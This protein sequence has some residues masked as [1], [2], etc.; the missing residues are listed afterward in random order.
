MKL[1]DITSWVSG[2]DFIFG[3]EVYVN[4]DQNKAYKLVHLKKKNGSLFSTSFTTYTNIDLALSAIPENSPLVL[5][6]NGKGIIH[7]SFSKNE[8]S[9]Y[10]IAKELFPDIKLDDFLYQQTNTVSGGI[11]SLIRKELIID[12][13]NTLNKKNIYITSISLG[14]FIVIPFFKMLNRFSEETKYDCYELKINPSGDLLEYQILSEIQLS[15]IVVSSEIIEGVY[16]N[17]YAAACL[18]LLTLEQPVEKFVVHDALIHQQVNKY[19]TII[20]KRRGGIVFLV[21]ILILLLINFAV[22]S[23]VSKK[24]VSYQN[25][26]A[27]SQT[28][29]KRLDSLENFIKTK[30]D[31]LGK[32]GWSQKIIV[33]KEF[34]EIGKT[35]PDEIKLIEMTIHPID[36]VETR[37]AK[38]TIFKNKKI[39]IKG[40]TQ[41]ITAL[42]DWLKIVS[43]KSF[44]K[45]LHMEEYH[46]DTQKQEGQF[47]LEGS[48]Y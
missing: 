42:N 6:W 35:I 18:Y 25:Q 4:S 29:L 43:Q 28:K 14:P 33:S 10:E 30:K 2:T 38:E 36:V 21:S 16:L 31:F 24:N 1:S 11:L 3:L 19:R 37:N 22:F 32:A 40:S 7:R 45:D 41:K 47:K 48:I 34:D 39:I 15:K 9:T 46:F 8:G 5:V 13:L 26:L 20:L 23:S 27:I 12:V 17:T 44:I